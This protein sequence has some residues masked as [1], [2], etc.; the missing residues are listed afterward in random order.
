[1]A[2]LIGFSGLQVPSVE[3]W[4]IARHNV[5]IDDESFTRG[6]FKKIYRG[7]YMN[8]AAAVKCVTIESSKQRSDSLREVNIWQEANHLNIL[9]LDITTGLQFLHSKGFAHGGLEGD[10]II[11]HGGTA[12]VTGFGLSFSSAGIQPGFDNLGAIRWR[13]LEFAL[14]GKASLEADVYS[15]AIVEAET[16]PMPWGDGP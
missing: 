7:R 1:M 16:G 14:H 12:M 4:F 5:Q 3:K 2:R 6:A 8:A 13:A 15:L 11:V 9:L 10:N